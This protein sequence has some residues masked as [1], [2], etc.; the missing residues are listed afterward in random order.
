MVARQPHKLTSA[1][2]EFCWNEDGSIDRENS[3]AW[4]LEYALLAEMD[5]ETQALSEY[6]TEHSFSSR[7]DAE[8]FI[9][10]NILKQ[11]RC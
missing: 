11:K 8:Y 3:P 2:N 1:S 7:V 10:E 9:K 4:I 5:F 6:L